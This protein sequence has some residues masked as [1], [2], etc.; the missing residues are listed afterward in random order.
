MADIEL[1]IIGEDRK[2]QEQAEEAAETS[3]TENEDDNGA[4]DDI[5]IIDGSNPKFTRVSTKPSDDY[6]TPSS[7]PSLPDV[8]E[9]K[10]SITCTKK[11]FL[12]KGLSVILNKGAGPKSKELFDNLRVTL[13]SKGKRINGAEYDGKKIFLLK[14]GKIVYSANRAYTTDITNFQK[15]L[16]K[17]QLEYDETITSVIDNE[18]QRSVREN[19]SRNLQEMMEDGFSELALGDL[20]GN[21]VREKNYVWAVD[22]DV[23][24]DKLHTDKNQKTLYKGKIK[25][26]EE[27]IKT[28]KELAERE[29]HPGKKGMYE[30]AVELCKLKK[31]EMEVKAGKKPESEEAQALVR[32]EVRA[33]DLTRFEKFKKWAK[34]NIEGV[35]AVAT[36]I[37]G[38]ITTIIIAGRSAVKKGAKA[39]GKFGKVLANVTKKAAPAIATIL[40]IL[41]QALTWGAKALEFL[42]RN[43]WIVALALTYFL[44]NEVRNR[45]SGKIKDI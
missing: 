16:G 10:R 22:N 3:F 4:R 9:Y 27:N 8:G 14:D 15:L 13:D 33:N 5:L 7:I 38:I 39:V 26:L 32:E 1:D 37:A 2:E 23:D 31:A 43:L 12:E 42:S 41:A 6:P 20:D 17:V 35:S 40:N 19:A 24:Y 11:E 30:T 36:S 45:R 34:E 44:Y 25:G 18:L 29:Q 21:T 28:W